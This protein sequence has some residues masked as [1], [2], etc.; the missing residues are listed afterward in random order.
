M[1][2]WKTRGNRASH[3]TSF[4]VDS[5]LRRAGQSW[6]CVL[7]V[8]D[9]DEMRETKK[10]TDG[11]DPGAL[12]QMESIDNSADFT[13]KLAGRA[14]I[15]HGSASMPRKT[16]NATMQSCS[17]RFFWQVRDV[18]RVEFSHPLFN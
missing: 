9:T 2:R 18:R 6:L 10:V 16:R 17:R 7:F 14:D 4:K 13:A 11:C 8:G 1:Y 3:R 15:V 5:L 12:W